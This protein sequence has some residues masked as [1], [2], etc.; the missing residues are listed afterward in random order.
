MG[1][2][3]GGASLVSRSLAR[4]VDDG[5]RRKS[6]LDLGWSGVSYHTLPIRCSF[7]SCAAPSYASHHTLL[8]SVI[9]KTRGLVPTLQGLPEL[10]ADRC[11]LVFSLLRVSENDARGPCCLALGGMKTVMYCP[12]CCAAMP[13]RFRVDVIVVVSSGIVP[14]RNPHVL[15]A[16]PLALLL[17]RM[18]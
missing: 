6:W 11:W 18:L 15:C 8:A 10:P 1:V 12:E 3:A 5:L 9:R 4:S 17:A 7:W 13:S 2:R 16:L 14:T